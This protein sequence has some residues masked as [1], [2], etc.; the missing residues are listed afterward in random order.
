VPITACLFEYA[1]GTSYASRAP[2]VPAPGSAA[3]P[4]AVSAKVTGL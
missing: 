2:C 3:G 1:L 4:V